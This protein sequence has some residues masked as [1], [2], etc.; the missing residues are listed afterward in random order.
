MTARS[1]CGQIDRCARLQVL[2]VGLGERPMCAEGAR[3]C[4]Y[5]DVSWDLAGYSAPSFDH[6]IKCC[7]SKSGIED[8]VERDGEHG[9]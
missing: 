8:Q 1:S 4:H 3:H 5:V 7:V 9:G 6:P 2:I